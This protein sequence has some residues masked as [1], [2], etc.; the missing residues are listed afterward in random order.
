VDET[1][2]VVGVLFGGGG[3]FFGELVAA[4][5]AVVI[6]IIIAVVFILGF[7]MLSL[8]SLLESPKSSSVLSSTILQI[9]SSF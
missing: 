6:V 9:I 2:A 5:A 3:R 7:G 8:V 1:F 4:F